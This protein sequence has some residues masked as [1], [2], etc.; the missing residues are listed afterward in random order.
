MRT[1]INSSVVIYDTVSLVVKSRDM[2][3]HLLE[4]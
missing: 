2:T 1:S 3:E 4:S